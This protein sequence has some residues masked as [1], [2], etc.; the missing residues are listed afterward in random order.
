M[1]RSLREHNGDRLAHG[2]EELR[3][4]IGINSGVVGLGLVG[5]VNRMVLSTVGDAVNLAARI[6]GTTKR[7]DSPLLISDTT[8]TRLADPAQFCIRRM[9]RVMVV[10]R[11]QPVTVYEVYDE[12]PDDLRAAKRAAQ[13]AFDEAFD[14]FDSGD[15]DKARAAFERC[16]RLLPD[17]AVATLH[18]AHCDAMQ[19]GELTPGQEVALRQKYA[20]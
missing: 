2:S 15:V 20:D 10:N 12:D 8:F 6:E 5:G 7:Y 3:V 18:L 13:P 4:G 16:Q 9:E 14:L 19:R 17:D 11:R 1:L